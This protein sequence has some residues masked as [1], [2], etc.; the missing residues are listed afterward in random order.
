MC[1]FKA[2]NPFINK[3]GTFLFCLL[4]I[5]YYRSTNSV[6]FCLYSECLS[7]PLPF[8]ATQIINPFCNS[9]MSAKSRKRVEILANREILILF[10]MFLWCR[11]S[12]VPPLAKSN[13]YDT[14]SRKIL[15]FTLF[16]FQ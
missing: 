10:K 16:F 9:G 4:K 3:I 6:A 14:N 11:I 7:N 8:Y 12:V 5:F 2:C 15:L 1:S 13:H